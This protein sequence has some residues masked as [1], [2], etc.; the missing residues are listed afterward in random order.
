[1]EFSW[2]FGPQSSSQSIWA[3]FFQGWHGCQV[4]ISKVPLTTTTCLFN[5]FEQSAINLRFS[6]LEIL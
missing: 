6:A 4:A 3:V 1:M 2:D 5:A